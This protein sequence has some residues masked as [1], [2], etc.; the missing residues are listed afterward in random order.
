MYLEKCVFISEHKNIK[1]FVTH[2][3]LLG[4]QEAIYNGV[5]MIGIPLFGDQ[6]FNVESYA[7][8]NLAVRVD[9]PTITE[10]SFTKAV[11]EIINN[12]IYK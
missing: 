11:T 4:T 1:A 12:P 5:P 8:K 7:E 6:Y 3:G 2:G 9:L 10:A